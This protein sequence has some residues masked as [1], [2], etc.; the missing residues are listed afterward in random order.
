MFKWLGDRVTEFLEYTVAG[1]V[2]V[3]GD[4]Y[5]DHFFA[6][7]VIN[8]VKINTCILNIEHFLVMKII[9]AVEINMM[10]TSLL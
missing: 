9:N 3:F 7:K 2:F 5:Y 8:T 6:M 1:I 10:V 4:K